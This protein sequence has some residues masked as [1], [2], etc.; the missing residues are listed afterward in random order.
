MTKQFIEIAD[1][2]YFKQPAQEAFKV[3]STNLD[4]LTGDNKKLE[5]ISIVSYNPG[6]GKTSVAINLAIAAAQTGNRVL[7]VDADLRKSKKLKSHQDD[8]LKG[9]SDICQEMEIDDFICQTDIER[10]DYVTSGNKPVDPIVFLYSKIFDWFLK[11]ASHQYDIIFIDS[12]P[13]ANYVDGAI[14]AKKSSGVLVVTKSQKTQYKNIERIK[15]QLDNVG[16]NIIGIVINQVTRRE[17]KSYF[18]FTQQ[19]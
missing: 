12:S 17:Y 6:E 9:M 10:L 15:W 13:M 11:S 8:S 3:L 19:L 2:C 1:Y 14:I 18:S 4:Q 5:V 7:Y 16:A